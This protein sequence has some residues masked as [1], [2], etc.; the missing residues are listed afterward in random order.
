MHVYTYHSQVSDTPALYKDVDLV[1]RE[2]NPLK[3]TTVIAQL[4]TTNQL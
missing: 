2:K 4:N 3:I 1:I